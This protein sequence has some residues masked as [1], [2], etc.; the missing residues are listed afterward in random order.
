MKTAHRYREKLGKAGL[1]HDPYILEEQGIPTMDLQDW[2]RVEYPDVYNYLMEM[3]SAY[4]GESLHAYIG[5]ANVKNVKHS[6]NP[7]VD[8]RMVYFCLTTPV[9]SSTWM[10]TLDI[11][12]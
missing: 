11:N 2:P 6:D 3:S 12:V 7:N 8:W 9:T 1:I 4:T 5:V 10:H